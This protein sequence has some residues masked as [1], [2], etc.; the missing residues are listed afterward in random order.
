MPTASPWPLALLLLA[1]PA[2]A[3]EPDE[4]PKGCSSCADWNT[5]RA[6]FRLHGSTWYVGPEGLSVL[7]VDTGAG[8][9][10]L[11]G[12]LPESV[13]GI[14]ERLA[15][16]GLSIADVR[17]ILVSH[18][19]YDHV[20]GVAALQ[21]R[22]GATVVTTP[23]GAEVLRA[24]HVE[25][26]DP[27]AGYGADAMAFPPVTGA[28]QAVADGDALTV[29]GTTFVAHATPGHT[30]GGLSWTW[31]SCEPDGACVPMVYADS[32]NP[33][34]APGFRFT[35]DPARVAAF[36]GSI[37]RVAGLPCGVLV[38]VHPSFTSLEERAARA[39][40]KG[41]RAFVD[42]QA[43]KAY[44]GDARRRLRARLADERRP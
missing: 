4:T 43:C 28:I 17:W 8:V 26:G 14:V 11:D 10:L 29:G 41:T 6:P 35:D 3:S 25:D 23:I 32:L 30:Q 7:A 19:H 24:G 39:T 38:S 16:V 27:Q 34:S 5:D 12:A 21:R 44:A 31:T 33:V 2:S 18:T 1:S 37:E 13:A 42:T 22:S 9:V 36:E 40:R 20:G 15:A